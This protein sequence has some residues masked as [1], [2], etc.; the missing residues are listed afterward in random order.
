[1]GI[2]HY[3]RNKNDDEWNVTTIAG[4]NNINKKDIHNLDKWMMPQER[5]S[6][7]NKN[8]FKDNILNRTILAS[9]NKVGLQ[10]GWWITTPQIKM[11]QYSLTV[12]A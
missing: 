8:N 1:V 10:C 6:S 3:R 11:A 9:V 5:K 4:H 12:L 2:A 7:K